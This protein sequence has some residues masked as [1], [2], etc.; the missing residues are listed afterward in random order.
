MSNEYSSW[1]R[2]SQPNHNSFCLIIKETCRLALP[3][4]KIIFWWLILD[5][6]HWML[7]SVGLRAILVGISH[8]VFQNELI[9][10]DSQSHHIHIISL[11]GWG[12]G[13]VGGGSFCLPHNHFC[14]TLWY[15]I[16]FSSPIT[17]CFKNETFSPCLSR[18]SHAEILSRSFSHNLCGTQTSKQ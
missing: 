8:L 9:I 1:I 11:C 6:F 16:H 14:S 13:M 15:N 18:E 5:T 12:P 3:W 4:W 17:I 10:E 7:L 2:T